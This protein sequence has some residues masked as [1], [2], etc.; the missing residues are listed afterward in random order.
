MNSFENPGLLFYRYYFKDEVQGRKTETQKKNEAL[1]NTPLRPVQIE[2]DAPHCFEL[3][4]I[5]PG[6]LAGSGY[7]HNQQGNDYLK[8]GFYF[9]HTTGLPCIPGSSVKGALRHA[10]E[11]WDYIGSIA[12]EL[13]DGTRKCDDPDVLQTFDL[14]EI[15]AEDF[16]KAVFGDQKTTDSVYDRDLFFDAFPVRTGN[17][18]SRFLA[19]DYITPHINRKHPELSPF[20]DPDPLQFLKVL[21]GVTFRF[22]FRLTDNGLPGKTKLELFR[23]ILLDQGIGAK[24]N[25]G[26]GQF[27]QDE[28]EPAVEQRSGVSVSGQKAPLREDK[29]PERLHADKIKKTGVK[30]GATVVERRGDVHFVSLNIEGYDTQ[31]DFKYFAGIETGRRIIVEINSIEGK[32]ARRRFRVKFVEEL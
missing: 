8:L 18:G 22:G 16:K 23:Q 9:D 4:T 27:L 14:S 1:F 5:Y 15:N 17:P 6:L 12:T 30:V 32:G 10:V 28:T 3:T 29:F 11:H 25:V 19:N 2:P 24:T 26:Y 20:T 7:M 13:K 31:E 21:P